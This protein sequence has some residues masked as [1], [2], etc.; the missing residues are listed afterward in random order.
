ME[1]IRRMRA[2]AR[3]KS[4]VYHVLRYTPDLVRDEWANIG[5]MVFDPRT[6]ERRF[7]LIAD[8]EEFHRVRRL[9]P[10]ADEGLLRSLQGSLESRFETANLA[11]VNVGEWERI[12]FQWDA[13]FFKHPPTFASDRVA[14]NR[15]RCRSRAVV[16]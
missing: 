15:P 16:R 5:V 9:H 3:D 13:T 2:G 11:S 14:G 1:Q 4:F 6:D 8:E 12:L 7:R 10:E